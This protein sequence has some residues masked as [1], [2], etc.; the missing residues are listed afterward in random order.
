MVR[1][2]VDMGS[3]IEA[4]LQRALT[5]NQNA[6]GGFGAAPGLASST[7]PTSLAVLALR[8]AGEMPASNQAADWIRERQGADGSWPHMEGAPQGSWST[9]LATLAVGRTGA[10]LTAAR[11][12]LAWLL[13]QE[14]RR[15]PLMMRLRHRLFPDQQAVELDPTLKGW[16]WADQTFGWIEPTSYALIAIKSLPGLAMRAR[17]RTRVIDG[18]RM[19]LDRICAGGGW[20]YGNSRVLDEELEPFPDTTA[21]ALIALQD[22]PRSEAVRTSLAALDRLLHA[23]DSG[24]T[25]ALSIL[26][27]RLY[28]VDPREL[29]ER[30][31][32]RFRDTGFLGETR[33]LALALMALAEENMFEVPAHV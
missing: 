18:E 1:T 23:N 17:V 26:C 19:I 29:I 10:D 31:S 7:E 32:R 8:A 20:N 2:L 28:G 16:P 3:R 15:F 33:P 6:D 12:G 4:D 14:A 22:V 11:Q 27:Y 9:S 21:L 5:A 13:G 30:L 24:L 25:L